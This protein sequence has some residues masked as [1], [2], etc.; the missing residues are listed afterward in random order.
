[1]DTWKMKSQQNKGKYDTSMILKLKEKK[2]R[3]VILYGAPAQVGKLFRVGTAA[4]LQLSSAAPASFTPHSHRHH[5][6]RCHPSTLS[7]SPRPISCASR[8]P[9]LSPSARSPPCYASCRRR[10][11]LLP[12]PG[13]SRAPCRT[14]LML[15]FLVALEDG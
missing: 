3:N 11:L 6:H 10:N 7:P 8:L 9:T 13:K 2:K 5:L 15:L 1:M 12:V 14:A 4:L